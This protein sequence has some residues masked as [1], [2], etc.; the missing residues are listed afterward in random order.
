MYQGGDHGAIDSADLR[1]RTL[2][3]RKL[4][5]LSIVPEQSSAVL[6]ADHIEQHGVELPVGV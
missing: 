5:L 4:L 2:I 3:E 1:D 6:F